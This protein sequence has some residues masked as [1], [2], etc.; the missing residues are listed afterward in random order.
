MERK[1][2]ANGLRIMRQ[3]KGLTQKE[4]AKQSGVSVDVIRKLERGRDNV[5]VIGVIKLS[6]Y[7][8]VRLSQICGNN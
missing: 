4:L 3:N 7:F 6:K 1:E 5:L 8:G 2:I